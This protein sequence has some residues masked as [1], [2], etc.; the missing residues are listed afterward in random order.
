M[1]DCCT[2]SSDCAVHRGP[3]FPNGPCSCGAGGDCPNAEPP[4][5]KHCKAPLYRNHI[6][7][8]TWWECERPRCGWVWEPPKGQKRSKIHSPSRTGS[9]E[10]GGEDV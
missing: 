10:I 8:E 9:L 4:L 2:H 6:N 3:A 5:C 7:G 1:S